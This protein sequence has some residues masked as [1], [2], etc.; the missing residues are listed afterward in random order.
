MRTLDVIRCAVHRSFF[1]VDFLEVSKEAN[2]SQSLERV[3][4]DEVRSEVRKRLAS[5]TDYNSEKF[6]AIHKYFGK[7][8]K[9]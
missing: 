2:S 1:F 3:F 8:E 6:P 4:E 9:R 7:N 5:D